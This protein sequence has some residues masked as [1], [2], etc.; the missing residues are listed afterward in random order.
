MTFGMKWMSGLLATVLLAV[1]A[2]AATVPLFST[3]VDGAGGK[4][5]GGTP[6]PHWSIVA[7]PRIKSPKPAVVMSTS[8]DY[9]YVQSSTAEWVWVKADG[10]GQLRPYTF[11]IRFN[12]PAGKAAR[13]TLTGRWALDDVGNI[14]LNGKKAIGT[15]TDLSEP[16]ASNYLQF[17]DF[18]I[19]RG[20]V[21][22]E[23]I[24][25]FIVHDTGTPGG[26]VV[27]G[28]TLSY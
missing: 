3:G 20:F 19:S 23:N 9:G 25:Q 1:S 28:L 8:V 7:G 15:G 10:L 14:N 26:L 5:P 12:V 13:A 27:D 11:E 4:L 17:N 22:G 18:S 6:D 24:L 16:A 21:V 2:H